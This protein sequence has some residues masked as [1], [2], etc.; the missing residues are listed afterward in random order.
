MQASAVPGEE[1]PRP[2]G[3]PEAALDFAWRQDLAACVSVASSAAPRE[4][5]ALFKRA[6]IARD[7]FA[8]LAIA[9]ALQDHGPAKPQYALRMARALLDAG[10]ADEAVR[11]LQTAPPADPPEEM[12]RALVLAQA[13]RGAGR[14]EE[15]APA[16]AS[17]FALGFAETSPATAHTLARALELERRS[18]ALDGW[19]EHCALI[20][21]YML[22]GLMDRAAQALA[23]CFAA[24]S[25]MDDRELD[26]ALDFALP[27]LQT[28]SPGVVMQLLD[29]MAGLFRQAGLEPDFLETRRAL[30]GAGDAD[31][32]EA[33][34]RPRSTHGRKLLRCLARASAR[35]GL[36]R[37]ASWR[38]GALAHRKQSADVRTEL[39]RCIG[40]DLLQTTPLAFRPPGEPRIFDLFPYNGE[41]MVLLIKLNEMASWVDRFVI[42]EA[43]TTFTG[44]PRP[45]HFPDQRPLFAAFAD[46]IVHV[47]VDAFP[48]RLNSAWSREFYQ[49]DSAIRG[50]SGLCAPDDLVLLS[51]A[52]EVIDRRALDRVDGD[53]VPA[54]LRLFQYFLNC[55]YVRYPPGPK[56]VIAKARFLARNG[57]SYLRLGGQDRGEGRELEDAGWHFSSIGEPADIDRKMKS[58]SHEERAHLDGPYFEGLLAAIRRGDA[59]EIYARREVDDTFPQH[60]RANRE[61]LARY[62]L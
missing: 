48:D 59:P 25:V 50:L 12:L 37:L 41:A 34:K 15:A 51:D 31:A 55:E 16:F 14:D 30:E 58:F 10:L 2:A 57:S 32:D 23:V 5:W 38:L 7:R 4:L 28:A 54:R 43:R 13:L 60:I 40:Q 24:A 18:P 56:T 52:D 1:P 49:R 27:A 21:S 9:R 45:I 6:W 35:G 26:Q 61:A 42:V 11:L 3:Q 29:A 39:A 20:T 44:K 8:V 19:A 17:A 62:L 36:W 46:K 47:V 22:W 53:V 33:R